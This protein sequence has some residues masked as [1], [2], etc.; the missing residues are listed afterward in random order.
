MNRSTMT[1]FGE[2]LFFAF[3]DL[4]GLRVKQPET[5]DSEKAAR[6]QLESLR[7]PYVTE[8]IS[9]ISTR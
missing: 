9:R 3:S 8:K 6:H 4:S 2:N 1:L 7:K 5:V